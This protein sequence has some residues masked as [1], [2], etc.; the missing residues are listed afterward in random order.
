M[1]KK[2]GMPNKSIGIMKIAELFLDSYLG[3]NLKQ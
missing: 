3:Q 2:F 1:K